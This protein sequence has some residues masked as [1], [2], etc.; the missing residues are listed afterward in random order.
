M[1]SVAVRRMTVP[2]TLAATPMPMAVV[3]ERVFVFGEGVAV[4]DRVCFE[5]VSREV[6][7]GAVR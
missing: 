1:N 5:A 2:T 6:G 4:A 3:G 7:I